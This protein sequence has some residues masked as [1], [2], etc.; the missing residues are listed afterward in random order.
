MVNGERVRQARELRG[1]TQTELAERVD[2]R[3]STIANIENGRLVPS[4]ELIATLAMTLGFFIFH[5]H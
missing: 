1:L 4:N 2:V 5:I 3:Q